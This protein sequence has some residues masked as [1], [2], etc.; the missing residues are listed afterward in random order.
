MRVNVVS[1][2]IRNEEIFILYILLSVCPCGMT[3][4]IILYTIM[5]YM[6]HIVYSL[7]RTSTIRLP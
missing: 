1:Y 4:L 5:T 3:W 2:V 7:L 6:L